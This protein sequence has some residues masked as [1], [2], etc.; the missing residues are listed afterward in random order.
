MATPADTKWP[1]GVNAGDVLLGEA[2]FVN[3]PEGGRGADV[4]PAGFLVSL[5][6][7]AAPPADDAAPKPAEKQQP[8][9]ERLA[10]ARL[11]FELSQLSML[12]WPAD[13]ELLEALQA[14]ILREHPDARRQVL[15]ARLKMLDDDDRE[16][17]LP[18]I[19]AA[20]DE[21]LETIDQSALAACLAFNVDSDDPEAQRRRTEDEELKAT[22]VDVLYRKGRALGYMELPE[23]VEK[24]PI[25]DPEAH[26]KKF[27]EVF[28]DLARWV[29][30]TEKD[31]VLLHI[32]RD[33]RQERV[34]D[35]PQAAQ[36]VV[37]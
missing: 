19:I 21:I 16:E 23:V 17:W 11:D 29:D 6:V 20:T 25:A 9:A 1:A 31:Y 3:N 5:T 33:R 14:D 10:K 35:G 2:Q 12:K 18:E 7:P 22:L 37:G 34:R 8:L 30:T 4:R 27:V 32:R 28:R 13:Q 36:H 24:H 26:D 15:V